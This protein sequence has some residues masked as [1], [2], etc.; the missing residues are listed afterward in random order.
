M[1]L[2]LKVMVV[3]FIGFSAI[4]DAASNLPIHHPLRADRVAVERPN[5]SRQFSYNVEKKFQGISDRFGSGDLVGAMESLESMLGWNIS[6]YERAVVYQFMGFIFVQQDKIDEAI[7][8]FKQVVDLDVLSNSQHQSTQF[9]IANVKAIKPKETWLQLE[10]AILFLNKRYDEAIDVVK[11]L[12]TYWPEKERYWET[13][14]GTYME[15]QKDTDAL[16]ALN[17]GYK[18]DAISKAET[19]ENLAR[20]N[21]FLEIPFQA[22]SLIEKNLQEGNIENS[23]KN[24]RLLLGAWTAAREFNKAIEVIDILAPLTGEGKLYIQKAM[25]LNENGDWEG[26]QDA[27][28]KALIDEELENP[29]DVYILR[30]MAETELGKY[31]EAI[32]SFTQAMEIGTE[33]NKKNA[34]AWIDYVADRR[35]S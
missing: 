14:A 5:S 15:M 9:N 23:E 28:A 8:V 11:Q 20:L 2:H 21:L 19:L 33:T 32:E 31:D 27:T 4:A 10:L 1:N 13:M 7:K 26:V 16:A 35:G 12:S 6:K 3:L 25:L 22:A 30:G 18:Y 29:G 17:L 34:E 24:L